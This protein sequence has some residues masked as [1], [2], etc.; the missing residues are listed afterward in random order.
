MALIGSQY[1]GDA[2]AKVVEK[3][4]RTSTWLKAGETCNDEY[5]A[6][7][8]GKISIPVATGAA[9]EAGITHEVN[10]SVET[11]TDVPLLLNNIFAKGKKV[12]GYSVETV[13]FDTLAEAEISL[14][15]DNREGRQQ[16]ALAVLVAQGTDLTDTTA[17]TASTVK[18]QIIAARKALR[19]TKAKANVILC[20]VDV[21]SDLL[22][23]AGT[24]FTPISNEAIAE[25]GRFGMYYGALV[26]EVE[27]LDGVS[28]Y[29]Y[30]NDSNVVTTVDCSLVEFIMYDASKLACIDAISAIQKAPGSNFVGTN[31][32]E[33][34]CTGLKVTRATSAVVKK[35]L[36]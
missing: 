25:T 3:V 23:V 11:Y 32:I 6:D 18:A 22:T 19:K 9:T 15:E 24:E 28:S 33:E 8:A 26:F 21:Y 14:A 31:I 30:V 7:G 17:V 2:T 13:P 29:K 4:L 35:K 20:S 34:I 12:Y 10:S 27:D 36:V 1:V 5:T 16:A